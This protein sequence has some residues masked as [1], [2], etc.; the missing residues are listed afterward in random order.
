MQIPLCWLQGDLWF[1]GEADVAGSG[2]PASSLH[3]GGQVP[4]PPPQRGPSA[5]LLQYT[6]VH[7]LVP[8]KAGYR[9]VGDN[10]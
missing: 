4:L 3:C 10:I 8:S 2:L 5:I 9:G 7:P 6:E 1:G